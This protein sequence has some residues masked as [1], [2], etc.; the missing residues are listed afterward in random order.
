MPS[1][2]KKSVRYLLRGTHTTVA[3]HK[4]NRTLI[5]RTVLTNKMVSLGDGLWYNKRRLNKKPGR[6]NVCTAVKLHMDLGT[7]GKLVR[8]RDQQMGRPW[9]N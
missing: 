1:G 7:F 3:S 8:N 5:S 4:R 2:W 9:R 6:D